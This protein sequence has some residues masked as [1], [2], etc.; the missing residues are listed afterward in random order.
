MI[1]VSKFQ[2]FCYKIDEI[3]VIL[4]L[5]ALTV[6]NW[7]IYTLYNANNDVNNDAIANNVANFS[8]IG[9]TTFFTYGGS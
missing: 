7:Q 3:E 1:Q 2:I 5:F 8:K 4:I 9:V 6:I